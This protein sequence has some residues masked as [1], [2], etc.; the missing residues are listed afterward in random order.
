MTCSPVRAVTFDL[1]DTVFVDD[2]DE[3]KRQRQGLLPKPAQRRSLVHEFLNRHAPVSRDQVDLAYD[4]VDAAFSRVWHQ[5]SITWSVRERLETLLQGLGRELPEDDFA[6]LIRLHEEMEL[7][8]R[9]DLATG[10]TEAIQALHGKYRLGVISDAI[11]SPGRV[12]R[13]LLEKEGLLR[14]FEALIFSD[15]IGCSKPSP[16]IFK[17]AARELGVELAE[18]VHV[19]DRESNDVTGPQASGARAILTTVVKDRGRDGSRADAVC[20]S[21]EELDRIL[22]SLQNP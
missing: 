16:A 17:A 4:T 15:E 7:E 22:D 11:F 3:P 14:Y 20:D 19:G 2:S 8:I 21:Y 18:L 6:E 5:H 1:W 13:Q 10:I 12:L 9:P